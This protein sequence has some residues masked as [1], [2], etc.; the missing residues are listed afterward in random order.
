MPSYNLLVLYAFC[1]FF[2]KD[3]N[4]KKSSRSQQTEWS[5]KFRNFYLRQFVILSSQNI[6]ISISI[7]SNRGGKVTQSENPKPCNSYNK[8]T[9]IQFYHD[10]DNYSIIPEKGPSIFLCAIYGV[11]FQNFV[12]MLL[13]VLGSLPGLARYLF[14][15]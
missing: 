5:P 11:F 6:P 7:A 9:F 13:A 2:C 10:H 14:D 4:L 1:I 12:F 3:L 15:L 8:T